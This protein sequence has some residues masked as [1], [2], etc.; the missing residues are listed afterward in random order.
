MIE[1]P[2][3][4]NNNGCSG[5]YACGP[6]NRSRYIN[7][8]LEKELVDFKLEVEGKFTKSPLASFNFPRLKASISSKTN[9]DDDLS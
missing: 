6:L 7:P 9:N 3:N 2:S 4:N 8:K 1:H 5:V